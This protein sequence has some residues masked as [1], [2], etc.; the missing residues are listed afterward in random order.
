M[1]FLLVKKY[2]LHT[3][4]QLPYYKIYSYKNYKNIPYFYNEK[5]IE[6]KKRKLKEKVGQK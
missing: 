4:Q 5:V 2:I 3:L 1:Y 6:N